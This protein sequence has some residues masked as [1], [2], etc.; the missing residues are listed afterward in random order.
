M[1]RYKT[2]LQIF[3]EAKKA[4]LERNKP[5]VKKSKN[6][7]A[8]FKKN[9]KIV[10]AV[11]G[12]TLGGSVIA[13]KAYDMFNANEKDQTETVQ[14]D[15]LESNYIYTLH[16]KDGTNYDAV[17]QME[18]NLEAFMDYNISHGV[19]KVDA[20]DQNQ[21]EDDISEMFEDTYAAYIFANQEYFT[22]AQVLK[23]LDNIPTVNQAEDYI[24]K[25]DKYASK[26]GLPENLID[27]FSDTTD[28]DF[29]L[30]F[31]NSV[32]SYEKGNKD[33]F[34]KFI[35]DFENGVYSE[36]SP[37]A[38]AMMIKLATAHKSLYSDKFWEE[39]I[40][41]GKTH[42]ASIMRKDMH[43]YDEKCQALPEIDGKPVRSTISNCHSDMLDEYNHMIKI[44]GTV[45]V[46]EKYQNIKSYDELLELCC[47]TI[48]TK[49]AVGTEANKKA[50]D[51]YN[52]LW[53]EIEAGKEQ[54]GK[55]TVKYINTG[56]THIVKEAEKKVSN[57]VLEEAV[58][59]DKGEHKEIINDSGNSTI[60]TED[61]YKGEKFTLDEV[62]QFGYND[63]YAVIEKYSNGSNVKV[64]LASL[65][66]H[67]YDYNE[68]TLNKLTKEQQEYYKK[69]FGSVMNESIKN[70]EKL[71]QLP[72]DKDEPAK[73]D[74]SSETV[75]KEEESGITTSPGNSSSE[76]DS[77]NNQKPTESTDDKKTETP[78]TGDNLVQIGDSYEEAAGDEKGEI[79]SKEEEDSEITI[80]PGSPSSDTNTSKGQES[81]KVTQEQVTD[82]AKKIAE[83]RQAR[84]DIEE[85][86]KILND[87]YNSVDNEAQ[88]AK[89]R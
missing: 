23:S 25:L 27:L 31:K 24:E 12:L 52:K 79:V 4:E 69:S 38:R 48:S 33:D 87:Y 77:N 57:S 11:A 20:K 6:L 41:L 80:V 10:L 49:Y 76:N 51:T 19:Y 74:E 15:N 70:L 22:N 75:K 84:K 16:I 46:D 67:R 7:V 17:D 58:K 54:V 39:N 62:A 43:L 47:K 13:P 56:V 78:S 45:R 89:T 9:K 44:A 35:E 37:F 32:E 55:E 83:L 88:N 53:E 5:A 61:E 1:E 64:V 50:N 36:V 59:P 3:E 81:P 42:I 8:W 71:P 18:A 86:Y 63:A 30:V 65:R 2:P 68:N 82:A 26:A 28:R 73:G 72:V 66:A 14:N 29:M 21:A 85:N 34:Y 60:I 40:N